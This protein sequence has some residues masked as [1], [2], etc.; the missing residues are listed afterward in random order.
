MPDALNPMGRVIP[1]G[2]GDH[3]GEAEG[4]NFLKNLHSSLSCGMNAKLQ[5]PISLPR[6]NGSQR[7]IGITGGIASGKSS[8]GNFLKKTKNWPILDAD[9][10]SHEALAPGG[11]TSEAVLK[12]YGER[13]IDKQKRNVNSIDR[14]KLGHIIFANKDERQWLESLLHPIIKT[15]LLEALETHKNDPT[16]VLIIP[17]LFE[18]QLT[19][20]CSEIWLINCTINQQYQRLMERDCIS[21]E[22]AKRKINSQWSLKQKT[23]LADIIINNSNGLESWVKDIEELI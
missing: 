9:V 19:G 3:V 21:K 20:I 2:M 13:V 10:Y 11:I 17:L 4:L 7:R 5:N 6:W 18:K 1:P 8:V 15:R 16:I 22:E 23:Q 14:S 12:R